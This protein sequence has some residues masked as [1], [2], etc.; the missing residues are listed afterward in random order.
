MYTTSLENRGIQ[1][2]SAFY[3]ST[4][5]HQAKGNQ[6]THRRDVWNETCT[7]TD[8]NAQVLEIMMMVMAM[9]MN[10]LLFYVTNE[11]FRTLPFICMAVVLYPSNEPT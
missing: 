3:E 4:T 1:T 2:S 6:D 11:L 5:N 8:H 7:G 10:F 9:T